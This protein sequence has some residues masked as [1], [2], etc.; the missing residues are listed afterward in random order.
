MAKFYMKFTGMD[1]DT[2]EM[3]TCRDLFMTPED[4]VQQGGFGLFRFRFLFL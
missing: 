3:N 4:A 1:Q 2:V